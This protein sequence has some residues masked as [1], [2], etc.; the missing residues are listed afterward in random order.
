MHTVSGEETRAYCQSGRARSAMRGCTFSAKMSD[1][2]PAARR[3]RW[4]A[5]ASSPM[6]SP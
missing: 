1:S 4:M 6:A 3:C 2:N 5:S